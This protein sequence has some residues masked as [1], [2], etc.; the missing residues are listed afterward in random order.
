MTKSENVP[1][2]Y[3]HDCYCEAGHP[4]HPGTCDHLPIHETLCACGYRRQVT[5]NLMIEAE[6]LH[7]ASQWVSPL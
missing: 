1:L 7:T 4:H 6:R 2:T 3:L 5:L